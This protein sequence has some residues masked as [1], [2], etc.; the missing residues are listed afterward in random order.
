MGV[1]KEGIAS[2]E[3]IADR[4]VQLDQ[5]VA[6]IN[7]LQNKLIAVS[8]IIVG[9][10]VLVFLI[11]VFFLLRRRQRM[12]AQPQLVEISANTEPHET[13]E[14]GLYEL[15]DPRIV[16]DAQIKQTKRLD[17]TTDQLPLDLEITFDSF[18]LF[19]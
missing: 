10:F 4:Q 15:H 9:G 12:A 7:K 2:Q 19:H 6:K 18:I 8:I 14:C 11:A 16:S 1:K 17:Q 5:K 3:R 13:Q